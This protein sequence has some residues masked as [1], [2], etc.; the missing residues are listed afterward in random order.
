[1]WLF[2]LS[3]VDKEI[4]RLNFD[5]IYHKYSDSVFKYVYKILG[6]QQDAE[7]AVQETWVKVVENMGVFQDKCDNVIRA[8]IMRIARNQ[9]ITVL[10]KRKRDEKLIREIDVVDTAQEAWVGEREFFALCSKHDEKTLYECIR[11]LDS[12]Y[13]EVLVY[14][15]LHEFSIKDISKLLNIKESAVRKR[16]SRGREKLAHMLVGRGLYD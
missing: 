2:Y 13:S 6:N 7:D 14:Y 16:L 1:M 10:R 5:D 4:D 12:I 8:Y 11:S 3:L 15:Y 9:S